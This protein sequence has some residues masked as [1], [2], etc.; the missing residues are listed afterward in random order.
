MV[1]A[2]FGAISAIGT[3]L[4]G[5]AAWHVRRVRQQVDPSRSVIADDDAPNTLRED[6][7]EVREDIATI[8]TVLG[9]HM[10]DGHGPTLS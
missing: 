10:A 5:L 7:T 1:V 4:S 6:V 8:A 3:L 2:V 9:E